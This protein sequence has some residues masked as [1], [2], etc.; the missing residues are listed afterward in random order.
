MVWVFNAATNM[1]RLNASAKE[2]KS[3]AKNLK[4]LFPK[5]AGICLRD[6]ADQFESISAQTF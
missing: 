2:S 1:G 5:S 3:F 4:R 6:S